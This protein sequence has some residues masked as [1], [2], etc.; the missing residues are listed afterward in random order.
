MPKQSRAKR[1]TLADVAKEVQC[2]VQAVSSVLNPA[3]RSTTSVAAETGEQIRQAAA[4][5]G[6]CSRWQERTGAS[7]RRC[8]LVFIME[9][10]ASCLP[11]LAH[12]RGPFSRLAT[13]WRY[14]AQIWA[15]DKTPN[16][17]LPPDYPELFSFLDDS[18]VDAII[19]LH[20]TSQQLWNYARKKGLPL[21]WVNPNHIFPS[22]C[23][24]HDDAGGAE[25]A[26]RSMHLAG[27]NQ[28]AYLG[29]V[30]HPSSLHHTVALRRE[31]VLD[32]ARRYGMRV[33]YKPQKYTEIMEQAQ[34][35]AKLDFSGKLMVVTY[36]DEAE[37]EEMVC[38]SVHYPER[39]D[40]FCLC[41]QYVRREPPALPF[42][43]LRLHEELLCEQALLRMFMMLQTGVR[44]F[45]NTLAPE[46]LVLRR[47]PYTR[48]MLQ[49]PTRATSGVG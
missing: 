26:M 42:G 10:D 46:E 41:D 21:V 30:E 22:N 24:L 13:Q 14:D 44:R 16:G 39:L 19:A 31:R 47:L 38:S 1:V 36:D 15:V 45:E 35:I 4:A 17:G 49:P 3:S 48:R 34:E 28:I 37:A 6:Y 8:R 5:L 32:G 43:Y 25:L 40:L 12:K 20:H 27:V 23:L 29:G 33:L 11:F 9:T 2:S 18:R 7:R